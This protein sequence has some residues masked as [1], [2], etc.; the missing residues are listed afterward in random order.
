MII[1]QHLPS[2]LFRYWRNRAHPVLLDMAPWWFCG[3]WNEKELDKIFSR[4]PNFFTYLGADIT[5]LFVCLNFILLLL[6]MDGLPL[7][8]LPQALRSGPSWTA[9]MVFLILWL[10]FGSGQWKHQEEAGKWEQSELRVPSM[11]GG[12]GLVATSPG[13]N[14]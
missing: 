4:I 10:L 8:T 3:R 6:Q 11:T 7:F 9:W 5:H 12:L 14:I 13:P 1:C 2:F